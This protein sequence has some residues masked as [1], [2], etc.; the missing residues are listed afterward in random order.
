MKLWS[1]LLVGQYGHIA[2]TILIVEQCN[3]SAV[4]ILVRSQS[5]VP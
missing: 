3:L 2:L 5:I 1:K 4:G